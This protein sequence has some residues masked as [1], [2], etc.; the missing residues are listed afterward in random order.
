M[1]KLVQSS[2]APQYDPQAV[3]RLVNLVFFTRSPHECV[4]FRPGFGRACVCSACG[5]VY[6]GA[7][8]I[9]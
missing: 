1:L 5:R 7:G 8:E 9:L 2:Q 6:L 4:T 3:M